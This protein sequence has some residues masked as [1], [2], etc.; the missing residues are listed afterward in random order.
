MG[1][2]RVELPEDLVGPIENKASELNV[3]SS[4]FVAAVVRE[5]LGLPSKLANSKCSFLPT[6]SNM[7]WSGPRASPM[8]ITKPPKQPSMRFSQRP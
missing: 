8:R 2:M 4:R 1:V 6:S 5:K 3:D 7:S